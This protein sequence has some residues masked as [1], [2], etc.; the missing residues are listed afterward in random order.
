MI[1]ELIS[2]AKIYKIKLE[3]ITPELYQLSLK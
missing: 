2:K 3:I 1:T